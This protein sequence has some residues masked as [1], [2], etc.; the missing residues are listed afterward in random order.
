MSEQPLND[1]RLEVDALRATLRLKEDQLKRREHEEWRAWMRE[2][3]QEI[4]L[5]SVGRNNHL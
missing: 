2:R 4:A 3:Q 5:D 1:L